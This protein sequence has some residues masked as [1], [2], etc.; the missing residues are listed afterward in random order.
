MHDP[1]RASPGWSD[2]RR[3]LA[4]T[5]F[6]AM[7]LDVRLAAPRPL[8]AG[9]SNP[10][11]AVETPGGVGR[12]VAIGIAR[13]G[14]RRGAL[15]RLVSR[16]GADAAG[17]LL[18]HDLVTAGVVTD[19]VQRDRTVAT[20]RYWAALE[21][22]GDLALGL[23]DMAALDDLL[24]ETLEA[25]AALPAAAWFIDANLPAACIGHLL[26]H[27]ARPALVAVDTVSIAKAEKLRGG[28]AAVDLLFTNAAEARVL[29]GSGDPRALLDAGARAVVMGAGAAGLLVA[30]ARGINRLAA[31]PVERRDVTGAGDALAAVTLLARLAGLE[32]AAAARLGR[33]AAAAV[34]QGTRAPSIED[35]RRLALRLDSA[36]HGDLAR[37]ES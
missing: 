9:T 17:D 19:Q 32:L 15:V 1:R 37:L 26:K 25:G 34:V 16:I 12:N 31:L 22:S 36:A 21:P 27:P 29:G 14:A 4:V 10:V 33:L 20:D 11:K 23:A 8:V 6:G 3:G 5:V 28:L 24:P 30:E 13:L 2:A 7:A 18:L 35:L